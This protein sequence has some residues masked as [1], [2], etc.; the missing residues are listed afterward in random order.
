[1]L[2]I[3]GCVLKLRHVSYKLSTE[4][5]YYCLKTRDEPCELCFASALLLQGTASVSG[6]G[7]TEYFN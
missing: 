7:A 4:T 3:R 2:G 5:I 1:M 6:E